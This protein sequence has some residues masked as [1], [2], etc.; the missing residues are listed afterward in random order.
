MDG[1]GKPQRM[2]TVDWKPAGNHWHHWLPFRFLEQFSVDSLD[3]QKSADCRTASLQKP[4][5]VWLTRWS[6]CHL[7]QSKSLEERQ[8]RLISGVVSKLDAPWFRVGEVGGISAEADFRARRKGAAERHLKSRRIEVN[9]RV[10]WDWCKQ[11]WIAG[12]SWHSNFWP[13][14]S[15]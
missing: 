5:L 2:P 7:S 4:N 11:R 8:A 9:S 13:V 6:Y 15:Y 14:L 3:W 10:M 12:L 1:S